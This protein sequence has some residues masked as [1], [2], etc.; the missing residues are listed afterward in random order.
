MRRELALRRRC[1][2]LWKVFRDSL[3]ALASGI[4]RIAVLE[5]LQASDADAIAFPSLIVC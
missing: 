2:L 5:L 3:I 1:A 4:F